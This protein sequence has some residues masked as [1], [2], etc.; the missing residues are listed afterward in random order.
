M[1]AFAY[2][3][4]GK[5]VLQGDEFTYTVSTVEKLARFIQSEGI[6]G[7][8][9]SSTL[10]FSEEYGWTNKIAPRDFI[11]KAIRLTDTGW[12]LI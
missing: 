7:I 5:L 3:N 9:C 2:I 12:D 11:S 6:N 10:D 1:K 4:D 8:L